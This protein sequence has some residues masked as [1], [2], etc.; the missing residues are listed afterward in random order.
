M[1]RDRRSERERSQTRPRARERVAAPAFTLHDPPGAPAAWRFSTVAS[2]IVIAAAGVVLLWIAFWHHPIGDYATES[3]FY[4]GYAEG[5]RLWQ[6]LAPDPARYAVGPVYDAAL[7]VVGFVVNDLFAAAK[8]LS[9]LSALGTLALWRSIVARRAGKDLALWTVLFL[10]ANATFT[11]YGYSATTDMFAIFLQAAALHALLVAEDRWAWARAGVL[12]ALATFTRYNAVVLLPFAILCA[13]RFIPPS[14]HGGSRGRRLAELV[15]GFLVVAAPWV[16]FSLSRGVVPGQALVQGFTTFYTVEDRTR[17]VQDMLPSVADSLAEA[18]SFAQS[19][20]KDPVGFVTTLLRNVPD[21]LARDARE[22]LDV[23][24]ALA[25]AAGLALAIAGGLVRPLAPVWV[26]GGLVFASLVPVFYSPRYALAIAP[27]YLTLAA[28]AAASRHFALRVGGASGFPLKWLVL[29]V[30]LV[31]SLQ[32]NAAYQRTIART[33]PREVLDAAAVLERSSEP[34]DRVM[35]RKGHVGFH[36]ERTVVPFPRVEDLAALG[37][38]ARAN[39]VKWL[40]VSWFEAILRPEFLYLVDTTAVLPGL[41]RVY[42]TVTVPSV[43]YRIGPEFGTPPAWFADPHAV[44]IHRARGSVRVFAPVEAA[45]SHVVLAGDALERG[46]PEEALGH[47]QF[48]VDHGRPSA[49]AYRLVGHAL[50]MLGRFDEATSVYRRALQ[51]DPRDER[52]RSGLEWSAQRR[53][54]LDPTLETGAA[55]RP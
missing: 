21:H 51:I 42:D 50:R 46:R 54:E 55:R 13:L 12:A 52:A 34:G 7:A 10:A 4:G 45:E 35:T 23:P 19:A 15:A 33:L 44:A 2:W 16:A 24:V 41:T 5:A 40:Y 3:D 9:I 39:D 37:D 11:R 14:A 8:L 25:A 18:R 38:Y 43:L 6:R 27:A 30:P 29:A 32:L 36:A 48:A 49:A 47:L 17:N 26:F 31:L 1:A 20:G 28:A 22:L 53:S